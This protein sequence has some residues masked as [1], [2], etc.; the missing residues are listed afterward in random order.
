M[1]QELYVTI[2]IQRVFFRPVPI[3]VKNMDPDPDSDH[4]SKPKNQNAEF[5][6]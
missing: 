4:S 3:D 1:P 6:Q 2:N 5:G